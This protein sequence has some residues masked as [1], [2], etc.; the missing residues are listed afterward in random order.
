MSQDFTFTTDGRI[1]VASGCLDGSSGSVVFEP[2]DDGTGQ[3]WVFDNGEIVNVL[4]KKCLFGP[5]RGGGMGLA[6]CARGSDG[7][8]PTEGWVVPAQ[9]GGAAAEYQT[10]GNMCLTVQNAVSANG[11]P[12]QGSGCD[13]DI[14]QQWTAPGDGTL[15]AVGGCLDL[16]TGGTAAGTA[17]QLGTCTPGDTAQQWLPQA[18][19]TLINP[20]SGLC[21]TA[22][23]SGGS[24]ATIQNCASTPQQTWAATAQFAWR[25]QINGPAGK[26]IEVTGANPST[27]TV[28]L[29]TCSPAAGTNW[30]A[31]PDGTIRAFGNC[32][33][34]AGAGTANNTVVDLAACNGSAAQLWIQRPDGTLVNPP[35]DR[36][37]YDVGGSTADGTQL[38]IYDDLKVLNSGTG[39]F[40]PTPVS[41][42]LWALAVGGSS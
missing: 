32:L 20:V 28:S 40:N 19:G 26:C 30:T 3:Q 27:H 16:A 42:E 11:T 9:Q 8:L 37:L 4:A 36:V 10:A 1:Q 21:L 18:D 2:C 34:V 17:V 15:R 41:S 33:D 12:V 22:P 39:T 25:G 23:S 31:Y 24:A 29:V 13:G 5:L 14:G 35:S 38:Q 6:A 7:N